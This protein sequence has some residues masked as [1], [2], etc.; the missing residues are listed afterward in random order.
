MAELLKEE[1]FY[2]D[3]NNEGAEVMVYSRYFLQEE[4]LKNINFLT[5]VT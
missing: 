1:E 3:C 5:T 2:V 4:H